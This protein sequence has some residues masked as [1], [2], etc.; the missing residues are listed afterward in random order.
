MRWR[1]V[2]CAALAATAVVCAVIAAAAPA[3]VPAAPSSEASS[4]ASSGAALSSEASFHSVRSYADVAEPVR[5]RIP[6]LQIDAPLTHL[7]VAPDRTIEVPA[8]FAVPGWFDEGPRPGQ[9]VEHGGARLRVDV[10]E[11]H[12]GPRLSGSRP[13]VEP[14]GHGEVRGHLDRPVRGHPEVGQWRVDV[15]RR[16]AQAHRLGDVGVAAHRVERRLGRGHGHGHGRRRP[17]NRDGER[18]AH[19]CARAERHARDGAPPH[20][21]AVPPAP[22]SAPPCGSCAVTVSP[23][24]VASCRASP[25]MSW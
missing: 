6:A 7:G 25:N 5:L 24:A 9:P 15:Q 11:D 10:P 1:A 2:T 17:R 4:G 13:L 23:N 8:D 12:R 21:G 18:R 14:P 20:R 22:V 19:Q 16:D 3:P